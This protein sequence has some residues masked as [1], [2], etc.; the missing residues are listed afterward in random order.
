MKEAALTKRKGP[1]PNSI[2]YAWFGYEAHEENLQA[3][4]MERKAE[5]AIKNPS[6]FSFEADSFTWVED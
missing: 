2:D 5:E 3:K 4:G 6:S 1:Y